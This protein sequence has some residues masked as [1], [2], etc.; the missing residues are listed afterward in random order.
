MTRYI[1]LRLH[2][3]GSKIRIGSDAIQESSHLL[4]GSSS[5]ILFATMSVS[6]KHFVGVY[7]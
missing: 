7:L 6:Q 3:K 4:L 5:D 1:G 2:N